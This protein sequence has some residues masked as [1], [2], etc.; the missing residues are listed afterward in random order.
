MIVTVRDPDVLSS[1]QPPQVATYLQ[2]HGWHKQ[3]QFADR[4]SLWI[5]KNDSGE[6]VYIE[7]PL[8]TEFR[9]FPLRM[10]EILETLEKAEK[11]SQLEILSD[12]FTW[13]ENIEIPGVV[14]KLQEGVESKVIIMGCVV[15]TL[16]KIYVNLPQ[17][18]HHLAIKAYQERIPVVCSGDLSKQGE[19]FVLKNLSKFVLQ[20][21]E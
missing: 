7:L 9:D 5:Q 16:R 8:K 14:I 13:L 3:S 19:A 18:E 20:P 15:G 10:S 4:S 6:D 21:E 11:R 2:S 17:P 1:I 12:L